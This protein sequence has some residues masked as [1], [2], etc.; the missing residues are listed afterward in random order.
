MKTFKW[1]IL[2]VCLGNID[3]AKAQIKASDIQVPDAPGFVLADKAPS[4]VDRPTTPKTFGLSLYTL[5]Q[6]GAIQTTPFWYWQREKLDFKAFMSKKNPLWETLNF[7]IATFKTDTST[8]LSAGIRTHIFRIYNK[9]NKAAVSA[10]ESNAA[11]AIMMLDI[12]K[13]AEARAIMT[14]HDDSISNILSKPAFRMEFAAAFLGASPDNTFKN[15]ASNKAGAWLNAS[16]NPPNSDFN[17]TLLSRYIWNIGESSATGKDSAFIDNG[18]SIAYQKKNLNLAFEYV[19][20]IDVAVKDNYSR[21]AFVINYKISDEITLVSSFGKNYS[22]V[23]NIFT[24]FGAK[25]GI[26]GKQQNLN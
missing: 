14:K 20:R 19:N 17:A 24:V 12:E 21:L 5:Q 4:A 13:E 26:A 16:Y 15:L 1:I 10:I 18:V 3:L 2:M 7:S 9:K 11:T 6:G 23:S 8:T 22:E 25:F